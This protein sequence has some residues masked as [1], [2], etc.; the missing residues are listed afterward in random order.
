VSGPSADAKARIASLLETGASAR[1]VV[2]RLHYARSY[3][4]AVQAALR[5]EGRIAPPPPKQRPPVSDRATA[6]EYGRVLAM[7]KVAA[8]EWVLPKGATR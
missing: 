5:R 6:L 2:A 8:G 3:V 7:G 1:D 4:F